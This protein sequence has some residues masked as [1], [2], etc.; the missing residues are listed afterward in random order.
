MLPP[1]SAGLD[2]EAA[3]QLLAELQALETRLRRLRDGV[4]RV[5]AEDETHP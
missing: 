5:L 3:M 1:G 4:E 2:R